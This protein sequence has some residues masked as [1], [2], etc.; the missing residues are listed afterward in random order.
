MPSYVIVD[1]QMA[2]GST[3][4]RIM[5]EIHQHNPKAEC[6]AVILYEY[7]KDGWEPGSL[8]RS[9]EIVRW[10][11][12]LPWMS[13]DADIPVY[14]GGYTKEHEDPSAL[15]EIKIPATWKNPSWWRS[16]S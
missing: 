3:V 5:D 15:E 9:K 7:S 2:S 6:A 4:R 13:P 8:V 14:F 1:D 11:P 12:G 16:G 10:S